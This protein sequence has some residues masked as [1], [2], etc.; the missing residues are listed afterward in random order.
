MKRYKHLC[1]HPD[2]L[3]ALLFLV[4]NPA[5]ST[6]EARIVFEIAGDFNRHLEKNLRLAGCLAMARSIIKDEKD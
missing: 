2:R 3:L 6:H 5:S 1:A 4:A